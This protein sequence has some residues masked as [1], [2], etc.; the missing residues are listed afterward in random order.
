MQG[1]AKRSESFSWPRIWS[2]IRFRG[3]Q[4]LAYLHMWWTFILRSSQA[5]WISSEGSGRTPLL[6]DKMTTLSPP[7]GFG[8][9][10]QQIASDVPKRSK[11][12]RVTWAIG[13][14]LCQVL[15][16]VP[17]IELLF[18]LLSACDDYICLC[19]PCWTFCLPFTIWMQTFRVHFS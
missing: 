8:G 19:C 6:D 15:A 12:R 14:K 9:L 13:D 2:W 7:P 11:D 10:L 3:L 18:R 5:R 17:L 1:R 16:F 4:K